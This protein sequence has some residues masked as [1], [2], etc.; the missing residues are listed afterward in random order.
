MNRELYLKAPCGTYPIPFWKMQ[1]V[2]LPENMK[3][4]HHRDYNDEPIRG[5]SDTLYFRLI[6]DL[7]QL[8]RIDLAPNYEIKNVDV[9]SEIHD[10]VDTINRCYEDI[11]SR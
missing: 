8:S 9:L 5:G 4:V 11:Y 3:I 2:T 6:H 1:R 10:V 7:K